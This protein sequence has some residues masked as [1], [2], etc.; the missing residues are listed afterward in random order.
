M[1]FSTVSAV[2]VTGVL[3]IAGCSQPPGEVIKDPVKVETK[4]TAHRGRPGCR[5]ARPGGADRGEGW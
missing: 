1:R 3:C 2:L 4:V 5:E